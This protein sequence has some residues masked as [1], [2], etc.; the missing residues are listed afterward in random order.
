[1][2]L[3]EAAGMRIF[4]LAS[5]PLG[6]NGSA[7][8]DRFHF[9]RNGCYTERSS[10]TPPKSGGSGGAANV[11]VGIVLV[12]LA[13]VFIPTI[14]KPFIQLLFPLFAMVAIGWLITAFGGGKR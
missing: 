8:G 2:C 3:F 5:K 13:V 14:I 11:I 10:N 4:L 7:M 6:V 1:M 9:D 12:C